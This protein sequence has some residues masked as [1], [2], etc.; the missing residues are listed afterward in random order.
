MNTQQL[1]GLYKEMYYF[2]LKR[3]DTLNSSLGLPIGI[4]TILAGGALYYVQNLPS[5][6]LDVW[7]SVFFIT[8]ILGSICLAMATLFLVLAL[9]NREYSYLPTPSEIEAYRKAL[10][11]YYEQNPN[12]PPGPDEDFRRFLCEQFCRHVEK[13]TQSNDS[14][15][16]HLHVGLGWVIGAI[17]LFAVSIGPFYEIRLTEERVQ[18]VKVVNINSLKEKVNE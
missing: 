1:I 17:V 5:L 4:V 12:V 7:T 9:W 13:N 16:G 11:H 15:S 8:F 18:K 10:L 6:S 14:K 2:E 3:K